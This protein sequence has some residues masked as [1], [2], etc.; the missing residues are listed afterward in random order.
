M[1]SLL[2]TLHLDYVASD[3]AW[4][5]P[6]GCFKLQVIS[7]KSATNYRAL[8]REMTYQDKAT[9]GSLPPCTDPVLILFEQS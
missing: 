9:Y 6:I 8:L 3:T 5:R 1:E 7:G 2:L 4:R